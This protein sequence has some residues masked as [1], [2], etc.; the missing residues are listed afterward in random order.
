MIG[1]IPGIGDFAGLILSLYVLFEAR[2]IGASDKIQLRIIRNMLIEFVGGLIPVFG[3]AFD[4]IYKANTKN[5]ELLKNYLKEQL[6]EEPVSR[7]PWFTYIWLSLLIFAL[8]III[9]IWIQVQYGAINLPNKCQYPW[10]FVR[11]LR[12]TEQA[13]FCRPHQRSEFV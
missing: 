8:L 7:F 6:D 1:L 11:Y 3:D 9:L 10:R 4:A 12:L 2:K 13:L 5:T